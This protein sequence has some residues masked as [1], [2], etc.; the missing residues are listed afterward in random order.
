MLPLL[1]ESL[2]AV[3]TDSTIL[4]IAFPADKHQHPLSRWY[5]GQLSSS[6]R[7]QVKAAVEISGVGRGQMAADIKGTDKPLAEWLTTAA[8]SLG[9]PVPWKSEIID[10]SHFADAKAFRSANIPAITVSSDPMRVPAASNGPYLAV[11]TVDPN[12][13]YGT[14]ET[15]CVFLLDIDRAARGAS[16][17]SA[18]PSSASPRAADGSSFTEAQASTMISLQIEQVRDGYG[19]STLR[20]AVIPELHGMACDITRSNQLDAKPF[21][22]F[23]KQKR[24]N[25]VVAVATAS[26]PSLSPEQVQ[27]LKIGRFHRVAIATCVLPASESQPRAYWI[28]VLVYE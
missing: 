20:P 14:Y 4:F 26:Y 18:K 25:G 22:D 9:L 27:R 11:N 12:T 2:N 5:A 10:A 23:L 6:Q 15:L 24:L 17:Q 1:A 3:S 7:K 8:L 19:T 21:E 13:Y 28:A 16:P